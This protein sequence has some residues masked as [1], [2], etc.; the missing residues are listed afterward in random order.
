MNSNPSSRITLTHFLQPYLGIDA[1]SKSAS[2]VFNGKSSTGEKRA[3]SIPDWLFEVSDENRSMLEDVTMFGLDVEAPLS[4]KKKG[5]ESANRIASPEANSSR[6]ASYL[7]QAQSA[8]HIE[9]PTPASSDLPSR[10]EVAARATQALFSPSTPP[11]PLGQPC[12]STQAVH[13]SA[14]ESQPNGDGDGDGDGDDDNDG[15]ESEDEEI[16]IRIPGYR[17]TQSIAQHRTFDPLNFSSSPVPSDAESSPPDDDLKDAHASQPEE[18]VISKCQSN[19]EDSGM[20]ED[21]QS[22]SSDEDNSDSDSDDERLSAYELRMRRRRLDAEEERLKMRRASTIATPHVEGE[23]AE[24]TVQENQLTSQESLEAS[25]PESQS[26]EE[27][28]LSKYPLPPTTTT[29]ESGEASSSIAAAPLV[30]V[31]ASESSGNQSDKHPIQVPQ[32]LAVSSGVSTSASRHHPQNDAVVNGTKRKRAG[33]FFEGVIIPTRSRPPS[34][35]QTASSRR[36]GSMDVDSSEVSDSRMNTRIRRKPASEPPAP[37]A[38]ASSRYPSDIRTGKRRAK[39]TGTGEPI[40]RPRVKPIEPPLEP[41][42]SGS[43]KS[44]SSPVAALTEKQEPEANSQI[45]TKSGSYAK[46]EPKSQPM[47]NS[48]GQTQL[49]QT[50]PTPPPTVSPS[51]TRI[52]E[53]I[54]VKAERFDQNGS[55]VIASGGEPKYPSNYIGTMES[56]EVGALDEH[57][58][59]EEMGMVDEAVSLRWEEKVHDSVGASDL[60]IGPSYGDAE[61][62]EGNERAEAGGDQKGDPIDDGDDDEDYDNDEHNDNDNQ[63]DDGSYNDDNDEWRAE[64]VVSPA[65]YDSLGMAD[66]IGEREGGTGAM[67]EQHVA[68]RITLDVV[69]LKTEF[70]IDNGN[71]CESA[72]AERLRAESDSDPVEDADLDRVL[73]DEDEVQVS[74]EV[75][76]L[77]IPGSRPGLE[78]QAQAEEN[79]DRTAVSATQLKRVSE[80]VD[81]IERRNKPAVVPGPEPRSQQQTE[82][83]SELVGI[84]SRTSRSNLPTASTAVTASS[85]TQ[86][87]QARSDQSDRGSEQKITHERSI[88]EISDKTS[89][90]DKDSEMHPQFR[91]DLTVPGLSEKFVQGAMAAAKAARA[92][93]AAR[94][95]KQS[96]KAG[97]AGKA[98]KG[99][100]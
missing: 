79:L 47:G 27:Y 1:K 39:G 89:S 7:P 26:L 72:S 41:I 9:L 22:G 74:E 20:D 58:I 51:P 88:P 43:S 30:L 21:V 84:A 42:V 11:F 97:K 5:K 62:D 63:N 99:G 25:L 18:S 96:V 70:E 16:P 24:T 10:N 12:R 14:S 46:S 54:V 75:D 34:T 77:A 33:S 4:D 86:Q 32:S 28:S 65:Q 2:T 36:G 48:D 94:G 38:I 76:E 66:E 23:I 50:P 37:I 40:G 82:P 69:T 8:N 85:R 49:Q 13:S 92:K 91:L 61:L 80:H 52:Q 67:I 95:L 87:T 73:A 3:K 53:A 56:V 64:G 83:A 98:G 60:Q 59:K 55:A 90:H 19:G 45:Q 100:V 81:S 35:G 57:D 15:D 78:A 71:H 6:T 29:V 31:S 44:P 68:N 93:A 17:G